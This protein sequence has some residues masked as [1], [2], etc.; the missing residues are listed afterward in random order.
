M[1]DP[2]IAFFPLWAAFLPVAF[3]EGLVAAA[4]FLPAAAD[5]GDDGARHAVLDVGPTR[6]GS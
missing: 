4:R 6:K 3:W 1:G 5:E 2:G